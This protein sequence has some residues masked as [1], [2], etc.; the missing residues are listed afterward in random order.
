MDQVIDIIKKAVHSCSVRRKDYE[1]TR[2]LLLQ[3]Q[4]ITPPRT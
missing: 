2:D 4:A 3:T 1:R